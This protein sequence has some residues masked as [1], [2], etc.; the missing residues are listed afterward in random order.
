MR[1]S[2]EINKYQRKKKGEAPLLG[3]ANLYIRFYI[4]LMQFR[5]S[6]KLK[7]YNQLPLG[8]FVPVESLFR[9]NP[10]SKQPYL[11]S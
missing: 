8:G 6:Y 10:F 1:V 11:N 4:G 5:I 3:L 7:S 9:I 2:S